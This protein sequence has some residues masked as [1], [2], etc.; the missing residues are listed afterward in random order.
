M[1]TCGDLV[2]LARDRRVVR[3]E[4]FFLQGDPA[5]DVFVLCAGRIKTTQTGPSGEQVT[6]RL[7][8]P[9]EAFGALD[10]GAGSLYPSGAEALQASHALI[11]DRGAFDQMA[12]RHPVI[13]RNVLRI[14]TERLRSLEQSCRELATVRVSARVSA[15]LARLAVQMGQASDGGVL[16]ALG[17]EDIAQMTGTTPFTVSRLLADWESRGYLRSKREA[18]LLIDGPGLTRHVV[19]DSRR[20]AVADETAGS[21]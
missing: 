2:R 7:V 19:A 21:D 10:V 1:V 9:G 18:V 8:G 3:R 4:S 5:S 16:V 15:A 12:E 20:S 11:W 13:L 6:L 17:R 14:V